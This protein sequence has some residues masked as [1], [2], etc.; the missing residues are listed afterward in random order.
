MSAAEESMTISSVLL[1]GAS[2]A[3]A[4]AHRLLQ[5]EEMFDDNST[6]ENDQGEFNPNVFWGVNGFI[7]C[8]FIV[9]C[10]L[11]CKSDWLTKLYDRRHQAAG[12]RAYQRR[13]L[14]RMQEEQQAKLE[15]PEKRQRKLLASFKRHGV[16]MVRRTIQSSVSAFCCENFSVDKSLLT[17]LTFYICHFINESISFYLFLITLS[18]QF[19]LDGRTGRYSPGRRCDARRTPTGQVIGRIMWIHSSGNSRRKY[20]PRTWTHSIANRGTRS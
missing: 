16:Q 3:A 10:C 7:L 8:L 13:V 2:E 5:Q 14:E 15:S 6:T 17:H 18:Y 19:T 4:A 9:A 20:A 12:D 1:R 11:C